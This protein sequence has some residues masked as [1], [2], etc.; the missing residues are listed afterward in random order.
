[1]GQHI[2]GLIAAPFTPMHADGSV[3][4][5]AIAPYAALLA[6]NGV[7]GAFICGTTGESLSL[8]E[9]E[10]LALTVRWI[11]A[12]PADLKIIV[13]VGHESL[14]AS[15]RLAATS[16]ELGAAAFGAMGPSFFRPS[17]L[18]QLVDYCVELAAAGAAIPF[19]YYHIPSMTGLNFRMLEF[20]TTAGDRIPNLAGVKF[21]SEDLMDFELCRAFA[22]G[23]YNM[24]FGRDEMLLAAL[25]LG[26][27]GA[28]G[29]TYNFA[30]P[31]YTR[32]IEA[33]DAGDLN[34][35]R[36]S[37]RKSMEMVRILESGECSFLGTAKALMAVLGVDCGPARAPL[38]SVGDAELRKRVLPAL[39][40]L[41]FEEWR[42]R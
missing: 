15:K 22:K 11:E 29:S 41:G 7:R 3:N 5:E 4:L 36:A 20:L 31:L 24:L 6:R 38:K 23:R 19:Y 17:N 21:T 39:A 40:A 9:E 12:A 2:E 8:T 34:T 10:R 30:A 28:I 13:H 14:E 1:M 27:R 26:A 33:F 18:A 25:A 16:A 32:L 37:Q 42:S 35:A